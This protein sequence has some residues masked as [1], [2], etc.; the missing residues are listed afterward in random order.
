[1]KST[2]VTASSGDSMQ[3]TGGIHRR[4]RERR[5]RNALIVLYLIFAGTGTAIAF[6]YGFY[7]QGVSNLFVSVGTGC[8][9]GYA[10][11]RAEIHSQS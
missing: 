9:A 4:N 7:V 1:M 11:M 6:L 8:L 3:E 10:V 2:L 5:A